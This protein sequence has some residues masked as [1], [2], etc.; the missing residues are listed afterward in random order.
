M[1]GASSVDLM[2]WAELLRLRHAGRSRAISCVQR[3][4]VRR[5]RRAFSSFTIFRMDGEC[6]HLETRAAPLRNDDGTVAQLGVARDITTRKQAEAR[7]RESERNLRQLTETIPVMLW[8]A[9]PEGAIDYCNAR[10]LEYTGF[11][12]DQVMGSDG[13]TKVL[14]PD[15]V[16]QPFRKWLSLHQNRSVVPGR[17]AQVSTPRMPLSMVH[18]KR[19]PVAGRTRAHTQVVRHGRGHARLETGAGGAAPHPR[20]ARAY[21]ARD[22]D[23]RTDRVDRSRSQPA[24]VGHHHQRRHVLADAGR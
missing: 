17:G 12:A 1:A 5:A 6:R 11:D 16:D 24:A 2:P 21:D 14:H 7:L 23:G 20:E 15:G 18:D 10:F 8:S 22:H 9:T 4:R 3:K 19:A 13:F